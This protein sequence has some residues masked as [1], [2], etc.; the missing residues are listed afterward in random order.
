[1]PVESVRP[2]QQARDRLIKLKRLTSIPNWNS[3]CR[4]GFC[5][6]LAEPSTPPDANHPADSTIE[7]DWKTFAGEDQEI[8]WG[9]LKVRCVRDGLPTDDE[10]LHSQFR[11]HLHRGLSY[12]AGDKRI[13]TLDALLKTAE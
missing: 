11:L 13:R 12:L 1:M 7:M 4:W 8:Y 3:L 6:S 10:T 2:S 9:L 5:T